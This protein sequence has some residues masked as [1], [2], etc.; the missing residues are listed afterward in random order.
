MDPREDQAAAQ[1]SS[2]ACQVNF[3]PAPL[4]R[5]AGMAEP[6]H[7]QTYECGNAGAGHVAESRKRTAAV[8]EIEE[9]VMELV[10]SISLPACWHDLSQV[11]LETRDS[12]R[13]SCADLGAAAPNVVVAQDSEVGHSDIL[14]RVVRSYDKMSG[15]YLRTDQEAV[16]TKAMVAKVGRLVEYFAV[17]PRT[18]PQALAAEEAVCSR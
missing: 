12:F 1:P 4:A 9:A 15:A 17:A 8:A 2:A 5:A 10:G 3:D 14:A 18:L 16:D 11:I 6:N 7:G 13:V